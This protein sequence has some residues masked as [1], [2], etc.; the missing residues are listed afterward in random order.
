V[1]FSDLL[2]AEPILRAVVSEGYTVATPVQ[3]QAIPHILAGRDVMGSAQTGT[4]KTAAFALPIL[5]RLAASQ[6]PSPVTPRCL[7]LCPTRELAVQIAESFRVYGKN[8]KLYQ[9][10]VYGGVGIGAQIQ[11]LRRGVDILIATPGRLLDLM[12]QRCV[13]LRTV[14]T[15]VLDEADRMLDMGFIHD[16]RKI[17]SQLPAQRQSLLFSATLP[18]D[19]RQLAGAI[20]REPVSIHVAKAAPTA[21]RIDQSV[22]HVAKCNKPALLAHLF[23]DLPMTRGIVF[24]RTKHGAD[25]LVRKLHDNGIRS[26]AIH[27]NKS[28]NARQRALENFRGGR[29]PLLVATDVAS[30]G[31]DLDGI[32]HVV[33]YDVTDDPETYIHRIGRTARAGASGAAI[34]FCDPQERA[35]LKAIEKLIGKAIPVMKPGATFSTAVPPQAPDSGE[36]SRPAMRPAQPAFAPRREREHAHATATHTTPTHPANGQRRE[37]VRTAPVHPLHSVNGQRPS[38]SPSPARGAFTPPTRQQHRK[39]QG[40]GVVAGRFR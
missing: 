27:G 15:L 31:I 2:L 21:D 19:I 7:V 35:D 4:G 28:Q 17:V 18:T 23:R 5:H 40:R 29:I 22:Y 9:A 34:S 1:N 8:L 13:D 11:I 38:H 37:H 12:N 25:K 16:I 20:L 10:V 33:N 24:T 32:T 39:G 30:R 26:E 14:Q 36:Q 6:R 3:A